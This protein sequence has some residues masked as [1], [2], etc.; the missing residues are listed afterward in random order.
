MLPVNRKTE[1]AF[2]IQAYRISKTEIAFEK[3]K[4]TFLDCIFGATTATLDA[5]SP[6][7][8]TNI[9]QSDFEKLTMK[10]KPKIF[11][12]AKIKAK[13][14]IKHPTSIKLKIGDILSLSMITPPI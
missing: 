13:S 10:N 8:K 9:A 5:T 2:A 7:S 1:A 14:N 6:N 3:G 11:K 4:F 12:K